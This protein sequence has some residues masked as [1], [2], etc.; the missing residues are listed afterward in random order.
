[1][2]FD[3]N[4]FF[5]HWHYWPIPHTTVADIVGLMDRFGI[6]R[7]AVCSLRGLFGDWRA[8]NAETLGAA[9]AHPG[10]FVPVAVL[11]PMLGGSGAALGGLAAEGFRAIRLYPLLHGYRLHDRFVDE[12]C[13]AAGEAGMSVIVP[14]RPMMNF[15]F[16]TVPIEEVGALAGRH[17]QTR[18]L[19]SGPNYLAE[20]RSAVH[21]MRERPNVWIET[22]CMQAMEALRRVVEDVGAGR[23]LF[24]T[25]LAL[26]Y[27]ACNVVKLTSARIPEDARAAV[28]AGNA[29]RFFGLS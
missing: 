18:F 6:D 10:R 7:A 1:M 4:A 29:E 24:G 17:P 8:S 22:S 16:A 12:V 28:A 14:T 15:R 19:L 2:R 25:G 21:V 9:A 5:G 20:Y 27:P 3:C 13:S 23:V 26:H 11:S